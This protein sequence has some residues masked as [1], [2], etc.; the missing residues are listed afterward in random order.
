MID[1]DDLEQEDYRRLK[2]IGRGGYGKVLLVQK[3][4]TGQPYAMKVIKK[5]EVLN[6]SSIE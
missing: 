1:Y 4:S 3:I 5:H 2:V 6:K